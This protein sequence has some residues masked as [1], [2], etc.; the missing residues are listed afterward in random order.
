MGVPNGLVEDLEAMP[1]ECERVLALFPPEQLAW[2]PESW[3]GSPGETFSAL[4]H[5]CHLR[6]IEVDGYQV[7]IRRLVDEDQPDLVSLDGY[8]I[9]ATRRY[10]DADLHHSLRAF[11]AARGATVQTLRALTDRQL[12][13]TGSFAEYGQLS[14]RGLLHYL[15]SHDVQH[16][17]CLHWLLGKIASA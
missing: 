17:A 3:G 2:K 9:A 6:D 10:Q 16:L 15:R 8:A 14:L 5:V 4:E 13:R 12:E 1:A 7:R 11:A